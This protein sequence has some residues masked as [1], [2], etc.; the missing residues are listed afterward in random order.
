MEKT[1]YTIR[2]VYA[3]IYQ[4]AD[5]IEVDGKITNPRFTPKYHRVGEPLPE[6]HEGMCIQEIL[7]VISAFCKRASLYLINGNLVS[8]A[9]DHKLIADIKQSQSLIDEMISNECLKIYTNHILPVLIKNNWWVSRSW[10]QI[11]IICCYDENNELTNV[12]S[13]EDLTHIEY[14]SF[15]FLN[16]IGLYDEKITMRPEHNMLISGFKKLFN[17]IDVEDY[18]T[19]RYLVNPHS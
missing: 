17:R 11:P 12:S 5:F 7:T 9:G 2:Y 14:L 15:K 13:C 8:Y 19:L 16:G 4:Y 3:G 10:M 18:S 1:K 6:L